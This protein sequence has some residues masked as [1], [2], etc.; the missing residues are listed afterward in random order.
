[1]S[2]TQYTK[3]FAPQMV[4]SL[5]LRLALAIG[6]AERALLG[7]LAQALA[8][9]GYRGASP[10]ALGFLGQLDCGVNHGSEIARRLGVSR[11]MVAKTVRELTAA[12]FLEVA[13]D[14]EKGNRKVILFTDLGMRL[15]ADTRAILADLDARVA[16]AFGAE[17]AGSAIAALEALRD[18]LAPEA[19][20]SEPQ[21]A[22][23][24]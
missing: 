8:A 12:G 1:M 11:Q 14:P 18:D 15:I 2:S 6:E 17:G 22:T 20:P 3:E 24:A 19:D 23:L 16:G 21:S 4:D 13:P 10:S 5:T 7:H 9:R